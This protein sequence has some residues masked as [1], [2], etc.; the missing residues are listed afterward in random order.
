MP[1]DVCPRHTEAFNH[2]HKKLDEISVK[3]D[4]IIETQGK[5]PCDAHE[6]RMLSIQ[7]DISRLEE[8][9]EKQWT[10]IG[11][12]QKNMYYAMGGIGAVTVILHLAIA[13]FSKYAGK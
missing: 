5:R 10:I 6:E 7:K 4:K 3:L 9:T 12:L 1:E 11:Q 13:I 2:V 8:A